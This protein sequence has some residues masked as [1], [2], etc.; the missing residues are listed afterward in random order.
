LNRSTRPTAIPQTPPNEKTKQPRQGFEHWPCGLRRGYPVLRL[1]LRRRR[2]ITAATM[3]GAG[4]AAGGAVGGAM[5]TLV[6]HFSRKCYRDLR[7]INPKVPREEAVSISGELYRIIKEHGPLNVSNTWNHAKDAGINGLN[8]KTHMKLML[9]WMRGKHMLKLFC[10]HVGS[11]KKFLHT[12]LPED[13]QAAQPEKSSSTMPSSETPKP[14][15]KKR[16]RTKR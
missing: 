12:T 2:H 6:R 8:S 5:L 4:G 15:V 9:K 16:Q 13:P 14:S 3:F 7:R 10:T 11:S 1:L